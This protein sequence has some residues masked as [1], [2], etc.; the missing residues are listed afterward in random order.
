MRFFF[1]RRRVKYVKQ[2]YIVSRLAKSLHQSFF[3]IEFLRVLGPLI[4]FRGLYFYNWLKVL[5]FVINRLR[6]KFFLFKN[7]LATSI[8]TAK[9]LYRAQLKTEEE[10]HAILLGDVFFGKSFFNLY[11]ITGFKVR[12]SFYFFKQFFHVYSFFL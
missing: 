12:N 9:S 11:L 1:F 2:I 5:K 6:T 7:R 3:F 10:P 8:G 4:V